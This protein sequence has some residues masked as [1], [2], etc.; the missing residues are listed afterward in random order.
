MNK[1]TWVQVQRMCGVMYGFGRPF[2]ALPLHREPQAYSAIFY[3][4]EVHR[5]ANAS[6]F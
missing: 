4:H 5:V 1:K 2:Y 3:Y 6:K